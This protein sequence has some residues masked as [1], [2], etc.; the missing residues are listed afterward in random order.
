MVVWVFLFVCFKKTHNVYFVEAKKVQ[1]LNQEYIFKKQHKTS[2]Q[3]QT[4]EARLKSKNFQWRVLITCRQKNLHA[5]L[6]IKQVVLGI[7]PP[8]KRTS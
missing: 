6:N 2:K 1:H 3:A 4:Y 8:F 7:P 5:P